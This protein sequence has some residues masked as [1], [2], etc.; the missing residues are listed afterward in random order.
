[1]LQLIKKQ[2]TTWE[3]LEERIQSAQKT[4]EQLERLKEA[5]EKQLEEKLIRGKSTQQEETLIRQVNHQIADIDRRITILRNQQAVALPEHLQLQIDHLEAEIN[6]VCGERDRER[7]KYEDAKAKFLE[8]EMA[9]FGKAREYDEK[10]RV[11]NDKK[12]V[13]QSQLESAVLPEEPAPANEE[14]V[15]DYLRQLREGKAKFTIE[16]INPAFDEAYRIYEKEKETLQRW[17]KDALRG[18]RSTGKYPDLPPE[19]KHYSKERLKEII[20]TVHGAQKLFGV[21][22]LDWSKIKDEQAIEQDITG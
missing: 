3:L 14:A 16:G 1:M 12:I 6:R 22:S 13:L 19:A 8:I 18:S 9:W 20:S 10:L 11:L 4:K 2:Q 15:T 17:A 7:K 21:L 5:A